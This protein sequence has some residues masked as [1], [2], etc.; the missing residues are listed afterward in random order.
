MD[1]NLFG[2]ILCGI[3]LVWL[4]FVE[5]PCVASEGEFLGMFLYKKYLKK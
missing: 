3:V 1:M 4:V 5:I 2:V